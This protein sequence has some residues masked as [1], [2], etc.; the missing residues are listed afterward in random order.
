MVY[1]DPKWVELWSNTYASG[2]NNN[3]LIQ[4]RLDNIILLTQYPGN[5][6]LI[7]IMEKEIHMIR[8]PE[9]SMILRSRGHGKNIH[10][11]V[12]NFHKLKNGIHN[13]HHIFEEWEL[14]F[15]IPYNLLQK[16]S[17]YLDITKFKEFDRLLPILT[18]KYNYLF[19]LYQL[20][21]KLANLGPFLKQAKRIYCNICGEAIDTQVYKRFD[22]WFFL[23]PG[24]VVETY[25]TQTQTIKNVCLECDFKMRINDLT[26]TSD[27]YFLDAFTNKRVFTFPIT[28]DSI[29]ISP[30]AIPHE[31]FD[32]FE[33][34]RLD[35]IL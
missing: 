18:K 9:Q 23:W 12:V 8:G 6:E 13:L 1:E 11:R 3:A 28:K 21:P 35:Q 15:E 24:N 30:G 26:P 10:Q 7:E 2:E 34:V 20:I 14:E 32:V 17:F 25:K 33:E 19:H 29:L 31:F 27:V 4:E 16:M 5:E 22:D